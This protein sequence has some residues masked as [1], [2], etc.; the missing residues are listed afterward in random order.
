MEAAAP[1][2]QALTADAS[3]ELEE[4]PGGVAPAV[5]S[6]AA[7]AAPTVADDEE[8]EKLCRYC[9]DDE[10]YGELL[11]PCD[12][13]GGQKWVHL[14]CLR[15]WQ[16]M[17]LVTQP[18]HP[19]F[20]QDDVRHH[21]C[22]VCKAEFTC[23]P[24]TR[25]ELM[26]SF[27][28][29][30]LAA[31]IEPGCVIGAH[32]VFSA[33]LASQLESIPPVARFSCGYEHWIG[34]CYLITS[35]IA[36]DG[37]VSIP[38]E[39]D[40]QLDSIRSRLGA[41][42]SITIQGTEL[43]LQPKGSLAGVPHEELGSRLATLRVPCHIVLGDNEPKTCGDDSVCAVNLTRPIGPGSLNFN[44]RELD[45]SLDKVRSTQSYGEQAAAG[46]LLEHYDGGPV[47]AGTIVTCVVVGGNS[48]GWSTTDN[49]H[50]AVLKAYCRAAKRADGQGGPWLASGQTVMLQG[51][52]ARPDLNNE[53]GIAVRFSI[54]KKRWLVKVSI[55]QP[56][57]P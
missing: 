57:F 39:N 41:E 42:L 28:G 47:E 49:L 19:R 16:R 12:C 18:T 34:G 11:A 33:E 5:A 3:M 54:E 35:V 4:Q 46:V 14:S 27:T 23:A 40:S 53:I 50:D 10:E 37:E 48:T 26:E 7:A 55:V 36:D 17:V 45:Q 44:A 38:V 29:P 43:T 8:D 25:H 56:A 30:E 15:R 6:G 52:Q 32:K 2:D 51:L 13:A 1:D 20:W 31:L 24:P 21:Q 22:N 9:F